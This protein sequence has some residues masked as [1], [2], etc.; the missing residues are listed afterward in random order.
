[1]VAPLDWGLGH[2]TRCIPIIQHL[3]KTGI[4]ISCLVSKRQRDLLE[5]LFPDIEY[6]NSKSYGITYPSSGNLAMS[7][8][9]QLPKLLSEI[10]NE[11][12]QL[13]KIISEH[14]ITH[15]I[16]DS[17]FGLYNSS[18]KTAFITHQVHLEAPSLLKPLLFYLNRYFIEKFDQL[19]IPDY[20]SP[21]NLSGTLSSV[22]GIHIPV[23]HT[24]PLTRLQGL[25]PG[26][27]KVFDYIL[28]L[29]GPEP[30]R[31]YFEKQLL[32]SYDL[33]DK[34][35]L[36]VRGMPGLDEQLPLVKGITYLN[37]ITGGRLAE[38]LHPETVLICRSG[39]STLMDLNAL[40]HCNTILIPTPG[41][42]EQEYLASYWN[43]QF[44]FDIISQKSF[45]W[46]KLSLRNKV[47]FNGF[48][49][50]LISNG[51]ETTL[52]SFLL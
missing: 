27:Q 29:S 28:L 52:R 3:Q 35:L 1:V 38:L 9:L 42:T 19:W 44:G 21:G 14:N 24:G 37:H 51:L 39:Y 6:I 13:N 30:Q 20:P 31:S 32:D 48:D 4:G 10:H 47:F 2:T 50:Q 11:N 45:S 46:D 17:R 8:L 7:M 12:H 40:N 26:T 33:I 25:K 23:F 34:S 36:V 49:S 15:L 18:V 16:S 43:T 41:Q 5:E 22:E